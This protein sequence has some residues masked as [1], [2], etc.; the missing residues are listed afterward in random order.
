MKTRSYSYEPPRPPPPAIAALSG[1][2]IMRAVMSGEVAAPP[3]SQTLDFTLVHVDHGVAAFEGEPAE[4]MYNPLGSVHGGWMAT[5]LDS[6]LGC[7][8]HAA[9]PPGSIYTTATLEVKFI[10]A[11]TA[12]SGRLRAEG[13]A[14]HVGGKLATADARLVTVDGGK[15]LATATA[16][17]VVLPLSG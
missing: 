4:W 11:V 14:L 5:L 7:A 17:C 13:K 16:T 6:A 9:L 12:H 3:I 1:V 10:R 15:L 8:V 2:E